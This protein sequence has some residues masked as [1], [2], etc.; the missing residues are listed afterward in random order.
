MIKSVLLAVLLFASF[1]NILAA[2]GLI[3]FQY[4]NSL[5]PVRRWN[6]ERADSS[7]TVGLFAGNLT[8]GPNVNA[9]P[10]ATVKIFDTDSGG[11]GLFQYQGENN[12]VIPI[13]GST[14]GQPAV[15]TLRIWRGPSFATAVERGE[16]TFTISALGGPNPNPPPSDFPV[17]DL[18]GNDGEGFRGTPVL[19]PEP[20][21]Y[22]LGIAGLGALAMMRRRK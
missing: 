18:L 13:P 15:L 5:G 6:N 2:D 4:S 12:A 7:F 8:G 3:A 9:V 16:Y 1:S 19:I 21:T 17:P 11:T 14:P 10:L 20:S 22:S